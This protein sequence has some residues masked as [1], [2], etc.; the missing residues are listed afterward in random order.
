MTSSI[1]IIMYNIY[2]IIGKTLNYFFISLS[3]FVLSIIANFIAYYVFKKPLYI[4]IASIIVI[5]I[6]FIITEFII[7][8]KFK[9]FPFRN[10]LYILFMIAAFYLITLIEKIWLGAIIYVCAWL[11]LTLIFEF[12]ETKKIII[13]FKSFFKK[14]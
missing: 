8:K 2:K 3:I 5:F 11:L 6:W 14:K 4:S 1:T 9:V 12:P 7:I 13:E 10:W